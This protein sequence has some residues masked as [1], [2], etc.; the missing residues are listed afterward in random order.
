MEIIG[1]RGA[2]GLA[3]ENTIEA[4][5]LAIKSNV[6]A[7]ESDVRKA[8]KELVLSH[9]PTL[10][11]GTYTKLSELFELV[12]GKVPLNLEIKEMRV[13]P[14]LKKQLKGYK[15]KVILS[16][17]DFKILQS[18]RE[19]F[20]EYEIAVLEKWSG[21]RAIAEASLIGTN[22]LHINQN[23]LWSNF[24]RSLKHKGY[25]LYAY[26]VNSVERAEELESWGVKG[27]FTDYPNKFK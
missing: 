1:H 17:F 16:S 22:R 18:L 7:I 3:E 15:G 11:T 12:S 8:G 2:K 21:I 13:I 4:F 10:I 19:S 5:K 25:D 26:T 20:P 9:D 24:V 14:L 27:I 6:D 23:W